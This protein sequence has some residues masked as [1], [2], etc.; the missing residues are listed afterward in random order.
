ME[1]GTTIA[2]TDGVVTV[3]VREF[4]T[5]PDVDGDPARMMLLVDEPGTGRLF[6]NDMRGVIYGV[7]YDGRSV[8]PYLDLRAAR[9]ALSV[10]AGGN[11]RGLQSFAFHPQ[12]VSKSAKR[13]PRALNAWVL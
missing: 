11:E 13:L 10:E 2:A 7:S 6:V 8:T 3:G 4:A 9:W 5:L 12:W 1:A